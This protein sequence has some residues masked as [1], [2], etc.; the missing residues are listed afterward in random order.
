M[1]H[2]RWQHEPQHC[3]SPTKPHPPH[4]SPPHR[5]H[6]FK[7][8]G[9]GDR[10]IIS[11]AG[12]RSET[13]GYFGQWGFFCSDSVAFS[14]A[15]LAGERTVTGNE[16]YFATALSSEWTAA[17]LYCASANL[18]ECLLSNLRPLRAK[19]S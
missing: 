19:S 14:P 12:Q 13:A 18:R 17:A 2:R 1:A 11:P 15:Q 3:P 7:P 4:P 5:H 6:I 10:A 8:A 16:V 9:S